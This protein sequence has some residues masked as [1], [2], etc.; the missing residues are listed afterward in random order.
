MKAELRGFD[1]TILALGRLER[2]LRDRAQRNA[3]RKAARVV[4]KSVKGDLENRETK[5]LY[6]SIGF[7]VGT[8]RKGGMYSVV[9]PRRKMGGQVLRT[10]KGR[11]ALRKREEGIAAAVGARTRFRNPTQYAHLVERGHRRGKGHGAAPPY[12]FMSTGFNSARATVQ[13][14]IAAEFRAAVRAAGE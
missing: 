10:P 4:V 14:I 9:G 7:K 2:R 5:L 1:D 12:P 6:K 13:Q 3:Q 11:R 8:F